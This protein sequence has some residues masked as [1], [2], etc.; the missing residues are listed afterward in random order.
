[1]LDAVKARIPGLRQTLLPKRDVYGEPIQTKDRFLGVSPITIT[2]ESE[3]K[4]RSEAAR[5]DI[6][7][8]KSPKKV[9]VGRGTGKLGDTELTPEQRDV[10]ADVGGHLAHDVLVKIVNAPGWDSLPDLIK[11]RAFAKVFLQA[12]RAGAA[13]ALPPDLRT[14]IAQEIVEKIAAELSPADQ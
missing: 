9:H 4:V 12:H 11:K 10:F 3:D 14:G 5:L 8:S 2:K 7:V 13:A 6:S 1:M